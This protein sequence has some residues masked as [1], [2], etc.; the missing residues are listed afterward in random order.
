[1]Q[2][3]LVPV[4]QGKRMHLLV[5]DIGVSAKSFDKNATKTFKASEALR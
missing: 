4:S 3:D 2:P 1:M 5:T